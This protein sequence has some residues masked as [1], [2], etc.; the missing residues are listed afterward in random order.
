MDESEVNKVI[1]DAKRRAKAHARATGESHQKSLDHVAKVLGRED[2]ASFL[3]DPVL[4]APDR[5]PGWWRSFK[6]WADGHRTACAACAVVFMIATLAIVNLHLAERAGLIAMKVPFLLWAPF[7]TA[8]ILSGIMFAVGMLV[9]SFRTIRR[10]SSGMV[11]TMHVWMLIMTIVLI[12]VGGQFWM[13][14][15]EAPKGSGGLISSAVTL[16]MSW[17]LIALMFWT[18]SKGGRTKGRNTPPK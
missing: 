17:G 4:K 7:A 2:W 5:S 9:F 12:F 3:S 14:V 15:D 11:E 13:A 8:W 16:V 6:A 18:T 1:V 10:M